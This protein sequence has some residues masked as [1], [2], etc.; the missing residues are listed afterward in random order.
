[1]RPVWTQSRRLELG[2]GRRWQGARIDV[3]SAASADRSTLW[4]TPRRPGPPDR[5]GRIDQERPLYESN[6]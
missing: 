1:M 2:K 3:V 5:R 4:V 6:I